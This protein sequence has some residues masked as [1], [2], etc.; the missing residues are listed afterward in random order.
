MASPLR[1]HS[2]RGVSTSVAFLRNWSISKVLEATFFFFFFFFKDISYAFE[3]LRSL[4]L[5]VAAGNVVNPT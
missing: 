1:A 4:G 2:V 5:F 3:G